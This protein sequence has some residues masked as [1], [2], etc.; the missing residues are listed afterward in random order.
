MTR[1]KAEKLPGKGLIALLAA[2]CM[3]IP[4]FAAQVDGETST[5][6][7]TGNGFF[8]R[9]T[10]GWF[11]YKDPRELDQQAPEP[12]KPVPPLPPPMPQ[13][14]AP[15]EPKKP[16][17]FTVPWMRQKIEI[18]RDNAIANPT[19]E[20]ARAYM[21]MQRLL[22][23]MG[24]NFAVA[25]M[26]AVENDPYL[27]E[28]VRFP[29]ATSARRSALWQV[30]KARDAIVKEMAKKAGLW[31]FFDSACIH[32]HAQHPVMTMLARDTGFAVRNISE[33]GKGLPGMTAK[34]FVVDNGR[35]TFK[36]LALKLTP[37]VV[38]V[39]PPDNVMVVAHGAMA[40]DE[41]KAKIVQAAID[42]DLVPKELTDMAELERRGI[43]PAEDIA[44]IKNTMKDTDDPKELVKMLQQAIG[45]RLN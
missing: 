17:P 4:G 6:A 40:V 10:E 43:V 19:K 13:V 27:N 32:C 14:A 20:N 34:D 2:I 8:N 5:A 31:F 25:G 9:K 28:S 16:E 29:T 1:K 38:M 7:N 44:K 30:D 24:D 35:A 3:A 26:K 39:V 21:Y 22:L 41:L 18:L 36:Q 23:D 33:D 45:N 11:F 37:A 12:E 15:A 42:R